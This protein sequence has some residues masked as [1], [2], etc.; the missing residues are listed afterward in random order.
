MPPRAARCLCLALLLVAGCAPA[1]GDPAC[2][3]WPGD[4]LDRDAGTE[5]TLSFRR[6]EVNPPLAASRFSTLSLEKSLHLSEL[7]KWGQEAGE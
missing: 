4:F 7:G 2:A 5:T 6:R 1:R 3:A